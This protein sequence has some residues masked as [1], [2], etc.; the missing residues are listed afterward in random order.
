M[1]SLLNRFQAGAVLD[2]AVPAVGGFVHDL[3]DSTLAM[4]RDI[5]RLRWRWFLKPP[6]SQE[7]GGGRRPQGIAKKGA[8]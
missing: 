8:D 7:E 5:R 6:P 1:F 2:L 3:W 4:A